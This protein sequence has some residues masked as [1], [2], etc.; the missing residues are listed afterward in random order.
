MKIVVFAKSEKVFD[1][2]NV[3]V[4]TGE[5]QNKELKKERREK[6]ESKR[7]KTRKTR[8]GLESR[9]RRE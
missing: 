5:N 9:K 4:L 2:K 3:A 8:E 7:R 6:R 1:E